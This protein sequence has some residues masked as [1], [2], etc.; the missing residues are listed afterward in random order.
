M[1]LLA[2]VKAMG[3]YLGERLKE[4]KERH[5]SIGNVRWVGLFWVIEFVK[6]EKHTPFGTYEDKYEGKVTDILAKKLLDEGVY[7][8][9]GPSWLVIS[10]PLIIKKEEIDEGIEK[11]DE[12]IKY[13]D[14]KFLG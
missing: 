10:P 14:G 12:K 11:L 3:S 8:F 6:D 1:D 9:N 5:K 2:H 7:V 4:L 13:L